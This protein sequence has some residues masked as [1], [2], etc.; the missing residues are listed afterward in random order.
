MSYI[1]DIYKQEVFMSRE[2]DDLEVAVNENTGLDASIILLVEGLAAQLV[3]LKDD[4]VR[5][6][7]L[8]VSLREK[9]AA[10]AAA[11]AANT[12]T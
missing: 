6:A 2:L 7:A 10:I 12:P 8:A 1:K 5:I 4:P 9:S 3:T 11:V